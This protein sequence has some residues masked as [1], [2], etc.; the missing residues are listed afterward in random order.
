[1]SYPDKPAFVVLADLVR[2]TPGG[3]GK[4][5]AAAKDATLFAEAVALAN[6]RPCDPKT[7]TRAARHSPAPTL[8]LPLNRGSQL[9]VGSSAASARRSQPSRSGPPTPRFD[10]RR[11]RRRW[12]HGPDPHPCS[13]R[14]SGLAQRIR[15]KCHRN[16][17]GPGLTRSQRRVRVAMTPCGSGVRRGACPT[18]TPHV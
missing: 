17:S 6:T 1:M 4:W 3:E 9:F 18:G 14:R 10:G 7:L 12:G 15:L 2:H 16:G 8:R 5:F 13:L 11:Q